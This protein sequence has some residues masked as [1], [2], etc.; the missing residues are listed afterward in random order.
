MMK[1]SLA[2][3]PRLMAGDIP[4]FSDS[5]LVSGGIGW[6]T[7]G[8]GEGPT[9]WTHVG[10]MVDGGNIG[11][12]LATVKIH[13]VEPRLEQGFREI[14]RPLGLSDQHRAEIAAAWLSIQG[15]WYGWWANITHAGDGLLAKIFG[16]SPVVF[17]WLSGGG[18]RTNCSGRVDR[19]MSAVVGPRPFGMPVGTP[20]PDDIHD[21]C[22][23]H[24]D[25]YEL[26]WSSEWPQ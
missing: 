19:I 9:K 1:N 6:F 12:E 18:K 5:S 4:G 23:N 20:S 2:N 7:R 25:E 8:C 15:R 14:Y 3:L 21:Y 26:I 11:E 17:R 24:P 16:G 22:R 13:P 10:Q